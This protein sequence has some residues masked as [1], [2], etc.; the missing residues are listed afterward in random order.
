MVFEKIINEK[1][2]NNSDMASILDKI[3]VRAIIVFLL[4]AWLNLYIGSIPIL[5]AIGAVVFLLLSLVARLFKKQK[6]E[7]GMSAKELELVFAIMGA[8][9]TAELYYNTLPLSDNIT[10]EKNTVFIGGEK[11]ELLLFNYKFSSMSKD[12]IARAY[13]QAEKLNAKYLT[14]FTKRPDREIQL[15]ANSLPIEVKFPPIRK[16]LSY[17]KENNALPQNPTKKPRGQRL[18]MREFLNTLLSPRNRKYYLFSGLLLG[19]MSFFTP[20]RLYYLIMSSVPL[21]LCTLTFMHSEA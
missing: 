14:I 11:A 9:K 3:L 1:F 12:E 21:I 7:K 5:L 8:E 10:K 13:N 2:V 16:I 18:G 4:L 20:F 19:V 17:L 15:L 6:K